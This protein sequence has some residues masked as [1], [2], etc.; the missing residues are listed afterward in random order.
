[1]VNG[2]SVEVVLWVTCVVRIYV[3]FPRGPE[4]RNFTGV[5]REET[6]TGR[7]V[8]LLEYPVFLDGW[9]SG[10]GVKVWYKVHGS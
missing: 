5:H 3:G 1:M 8:L 9:V 10:T 7:D 6:H 2:W 4:V